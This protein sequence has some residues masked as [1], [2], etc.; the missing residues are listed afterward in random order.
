MEFV[1]LVRF[2]PDSDL[3]RT[4]QGVEMFREQLAQNGGTLTQAG[5]VLGD[6]DLILTGQATSIEH[7][8]KTILAVSSSTDWKTRTY[9]V[10]PI[11]TF[12][13]YADEVFATTGHAAKR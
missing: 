9:P 13:K 8:L 1:T 12:T 6:Y 2:G 7:V 4:K 3:P 10:I 11:D 5:I